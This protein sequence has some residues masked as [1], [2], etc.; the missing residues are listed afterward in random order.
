MRSARPCQPENVSP[1][2]VEQWNEGQGA[3]RQRVA[4]EAAPGLSLRQRSVGT[5]HISPRPRVLVVRAVL[6]AVDVTAIPHPVSSIVSYSFQSH[7]SFLQSPE[8]AFDEGLRLG[9]AVAAA[10]MRD[11]EQLAPSGTCDRSQRCRARRFGSVAERLEFSGGAFSRSVEQ[12]ITGDSRY[13]PRRAVRGLVE[14]TSWRTARSS[15]EGSTCPARAEGRGSAEDRGGRLRSY[16]RKEPSSGRWP[17]PAD[18][19]PLRA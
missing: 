14:S 10:A 6:L 2:K 11:R 3:S 19:E 13:S 15:H 9:I 17:S 1:P 4:P 16:A 12:P 18:V 5:G 8:P 7:L